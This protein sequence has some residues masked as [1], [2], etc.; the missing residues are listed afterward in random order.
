MEN[1]TKNKIILINPHELIAH[2]KVNIFHAIYIYLK[3]IFSGHF[4]VPVLI[5]SRTK[6]I[7]DGHHRVYAANRLGLKKV[8]CCVIDYIENTSIQV[9]TRRRDIF[10]N[11]AEVVKMALS[12]KVFPDK[13]TKHVYKISSFRSF[14]LKELWE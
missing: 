12:P 13:T 8:P 14:L 9:E 1:E 2:E 11:K 7:L 4:D 5:D 3:M 10:I 6:I